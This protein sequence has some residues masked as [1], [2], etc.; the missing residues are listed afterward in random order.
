MLR[1]LSIRNL[2][3]IEHVQVE[4]EPGLNVLTGE[5]GAGKSILVEAVGLLLGG[6]AS[7]DLVRT[8][9]DTAQVEGQFED[10][11][12]EVVVRREVTAQ[13][14]SRAFID[15]ALA[16]ATS[17]RD[18]SDRLIELHGQHEHQVLLDPA[19][20]LDLLDAYAG[21]EDRRAHV[22]D[23]FARLQ[24]L[25]T[26]LQALQLDER[27]KAARVDLLT[28]QRDEIARA[29]LRAGEDDELTGARQVL[30][31]AEKLQR[32]SAEA[33][34]L[35][36]DSEDAVLGS[37]TGVWRRVDELAAL[38]PRAHPYMESRDAIKSQ[39][40]DLAYFLR[41]YSE[42]ID[43]SPGRLNEV[44][45]RLVLIERL[46]R[47]YGPTLADVLAHH[48]RCEEDLTA[49]AH[50]DDRAVQ[51]STDLDRARTDY[52]TEAGALSAERRKAADTF[53]SALEASLAELAMART[54]FEVRFQPGAAG[55]ATWTARGTD[56]AE[57]LLSPNPGE[58]LRPLSRIASGG[59][60][61]R[62]MLALRGLARP[63]GR[64]P[65]LIFDEVDAG[66]GGRAADDVG[67]RLRELGRDAQVL[68]ITHLPQI[69]AAGAAHFR[70]I[71]AVR[72]DRTIAAVER[73]RD[74]ER[75]EE[76][77]RMMAGAAVTSAALLSA[78]DL[79]GVHGESEKRA[80][81]ESETQKAKGRK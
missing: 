12:R 67:R 54:R 74:E 8:G 49:V 44:E 7:S 20:H 77:A 30:A 32:L 28:F 27:Q 22:A 26:E 14:R 57:F 1:Y 81:G 16:T 79:L 80:K 21:L 17:L 76:L 36:Y 69:A 56:Q 9:E 68:C 37:L 62:V 33:Y 23:A 59:E 45:D 64:A 15:G 47:K 40:E 42:A 5:T 39:L 53:A 10:G 13:G 75:P 38:D 29:R 11:G 61:S 4:F 19:S 35:L 73:L 63:S 66:I 34:S 60:L 41:S 71:K 6:R 25:R 58:D 50:L 78:R 51:V 52:L 18:L 72:G 70:V 55:E 31:N 3:V 24:A 48:D 2:A 65:T 43:A 46:K